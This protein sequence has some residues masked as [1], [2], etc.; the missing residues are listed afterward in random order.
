MTGIASAQETP[1]PLSEND[2]II[3]Q[4]SDELQQKSIL[5]QNTA[6]QII[7]LQNKK[8]DLEQQ[9]ADQQKAIAD[10]KH[11]LADKKAAA[12]AEQ[13]RLAEIKAKFVHVVTYAPDSDG[14]TYAPG[15]CTWYVKSRRPDLPNNLGNANTWYT[16]AAEDGFSVGSQPKKGAVGTTTRGSL[17][18]VVYVEGLN[19]D[20]TITISEMNYSGLYSVRTRTADP[21]EFSYIYEL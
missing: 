8:S 3:Q 20:G 1:R 15:N 17:G 10:L 4:K 16:I 2:L 13:A 5:L 9:L 7:D 19:S 14:N 18:H 12:E 21:S 6:Q 11:E